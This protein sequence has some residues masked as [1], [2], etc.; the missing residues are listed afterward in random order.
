MSGKVDG[1]LRIPL[2]QVRAG[3]N[4]ISLQ[5]LHEYNMSQNHVLVDDQSESSI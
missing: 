1:V 2:V 5:N 4:E 3:S